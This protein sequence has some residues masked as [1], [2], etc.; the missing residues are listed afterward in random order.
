MSIF[1]SKTEHLSLGARGEKAAVNYLKKCN[2]KILAT[3]FFNPKGRRLG[4]IDIIA[5]D[6]KELVFIEVK[7]RKSSSANV[8][9][10]EEN[11]TR[12]KLYKL[13]K[14]AYF[15]LSKNG[16]L[17]APYRFDALAILA[18]PENN[19]CTIKHFKNIFL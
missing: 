11:V 8:I 10:P 14:T 1:S 15:Y 12:S 18:N 2:Y 3:N 13:N 19:H 4:E 16:L 6:G 7:T 9:L 17:D 5:K